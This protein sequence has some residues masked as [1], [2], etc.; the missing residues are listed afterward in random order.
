MK[1]LTLFLIFSL[2]FLNNLPAQNSNLAK[3]LVFHDKN[4]NGIYDSGEPGI[5]HVAVSNGVDVALTDANGNFSIA[6]NDD[7]IIFV[8]K[9]GS[10]KFPV[11]EYNLPQ[12]FY[13]HKPAGSP[14]LKYA[15]VSP[16]G[17]LPE[18]INFPLLTGHSGDEFAMIVVSDP[19]AYTLE[20]ID[21]YDR[22]IVEDLVGNTYPLFGITLGDIVGDNLDFF[23]PTNKATSRIGLPWFHVFGNH[24]MNF[25]AKTWQHADET[26]E[27]VY[28]PATYAFNQGK[29]HFIVLNNV[30][31][32][33]D[34]TD[35]FYIGG[36]RETHF[37]FIENSLKHVP[38]DH[39]VVLCMHI[40][41]FDEELWGDTFLDDHRERL[42]DLLKGYSHTFSMSGHTHYQRH[43]YFGNDEGWYDNK[44]HHHYNVGTAS[45]DWWSGSPD[46]RGI[47]AATMYDG[48]PNG[49]NIIRFKGNAYTYD[50]KAAGFDES[51]KMRLYG[52]KLVPRN[53]FFKGELY[54]NYFQ[55]SPLDTVEFMVN[56]GEWRKMR[57]VVEQD[58][59]ISAIRYE[60]DHADALPS[61][62]RPSNPLISYHLW[63]TRIPTNVPAGEN[64][65]YIRIKDKQGRMIM[66]EFRFVAVDLD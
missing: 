29:V 4:E 54:V 56:E 59:H 18:S 10:Y 37:S 32:P 50:Y 42:F 52:P 25:D 51:Y 30:I 16:T 44:P 20:Q 12:F 23:E 55:G 2:F 13:N 19:Q 6:V 63:K 64:I 47:P 11:N 39:L 8:I 24:D 3:G 28:G 60:W 17:S 66:D 31:F 26:F 40:P 46:D 43:Y 1:T 38:K 35:H 41:L 14:E 65:V 57:Y 34:L 22:D 7:N 49:Y 5:P 58:P 15:G 21:F 48:T 27:R 53:R 62:T 61:G 33:N 36:L 9:P 45:G